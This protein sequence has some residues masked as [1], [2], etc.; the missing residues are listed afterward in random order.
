LLFFSIVC[1][2]MGFGDPRDLGSHNPGPRDWA[3][4]LAGRVG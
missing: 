4:P 3:V 2:M 1:K